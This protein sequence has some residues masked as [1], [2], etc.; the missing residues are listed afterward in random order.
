M[1]SV[2]ICPACARRLTVPEE[3]I[4]RPVKCPMCG[5]AFTAGDAGTGP[6][7]P[8]PANPDARLSEADE[9]SLKRSP[10]RSTGS[11]LEQAEAGD[12]TDENDFGMASRR[13]ERALVA[14]REARSAVIG[15]A[16]GLIITGILSSICGSCDGMARVIN[17]STG[18]AGSR[19]DQASNNPAVQAGYIFGGTMCGF[20][21]VIAGPVVGIPIVVGAL[22]MQKLQAYGFA[23]TVSILAMVPLTSACFP[24]GLPIGIWALVVLSRADVKQAFA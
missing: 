19:F 13:D 21:D 24:L 2:T 11:V 7:P 22:K 16:I 6:A 18:A 23:V 20:W 14:R 12:P 3:L 4:G 10:I 17:L 5:T 15:P 1:S 9:P 8:V